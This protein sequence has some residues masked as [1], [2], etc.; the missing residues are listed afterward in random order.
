MAKKII[1]TIVVIFLFV[2]T[3]SADKIDLISDKYIIYNMNDNSVLAESGSN[4]KTSIASLTKIMTVIVAIENIDNFDEKIKI[5]RPMIEDIAWDVAVVGFKVGD[6]VTYNDLLYGAILSSGADAV[7]ALAIS[8]SG[9]LNNFV[10]LMNQKVAELNLK[11]THFENVT[12]LYGSNHFSTAYDMSRILIY[13]LKN[14]KFKDVFETGYYTSTNN[15]KMKSTIMSY[16]SSNRN[17]SYITGAK[18]GYISKAGYCLA[19]TATLN[20]VNYL[21]VTLNAFNDKNSPHIKDAIKMYKYYDDNYEYK[22]IVDITDVVVTLKTK[23]AK[24]KE[25]DIFSNVTLESFLKKTFNKDDLEYDY[26]G[27]NEIS[28]F[29]KQGIKLG[30]VKILYNEEELANFDLIYN[31]VL[32]FSIWLFLWDYKYYILSVILFIM[33]LIFIK[34][35]KR[36]RRRHSAY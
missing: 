1:S 19:S 11:N 2:T 24:E 28:Y 27:I 34:K 20:N 26:N 36:K 7:N 33:L 32:T 8:V 21:L 3:V 5:T 16:N 14:E 18:T 22:N 17:I 23:Y 35:N 4:E 10:S 29:T 6:S 25:I 9:S 30:N 13:A 15:I 31:G 12:G